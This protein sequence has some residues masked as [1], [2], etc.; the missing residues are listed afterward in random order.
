MTG[1]VR[2]T[3]KESRQ[4]V[5]K[6][7][8]KCGSVK[9]ESLILKSIHI[10]PMLHDLG[11]EK[12]YYAVVLMYVCYGNRPHEAAIWVGPPR[13]VSHGKTKELCYRCIS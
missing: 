11:G 8:R 3:R 5:I 6:V 12:G 10:V 13:A 9:I 7:L 2:A 4:I 1:T